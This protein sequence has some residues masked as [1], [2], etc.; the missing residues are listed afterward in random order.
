MDKVRLDEVEPLEEYARHRDGVRRRM[1]ELRTRRRIALGDRI[2]LSFENRE[3]VGY[4]IQEMC[5]AEGIRKPE[6]V[7]HEVETYNDLIPGEGELSATLMIE[8]TET[9]RIKPELDRLLGLDL[10]GVVTMRVGA[11]TVPVAWE[12]G[13]SDERRIAA[14]Q[15]VRFQLSEPARKALLAG[16]EVTFLVAHP[17]YQAMAH[18]GDDLKREL[19]ADLGAPDGGEPE[20]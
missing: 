5:H 6:A 18:A 14:V 10:E 17:N 3:T 12:A 20:A 4:Q 9:E 13:H 8:I 11:H 1:M 19:R 15:Y 7:G 16:A 2:S